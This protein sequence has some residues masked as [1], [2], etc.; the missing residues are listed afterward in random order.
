M[1]DFVTSLPYCPY[2]AF[3]TKGD[4][5]SRA[6]TPEIKKKAKEQR[7]IVDYSVRVPECMNYKKN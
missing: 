7:V 4:T 5:C 6:L 2:Y 3:C 1:K